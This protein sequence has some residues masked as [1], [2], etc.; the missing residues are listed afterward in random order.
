MKIK[1]TYKLVALLVVPLLHAETAQE[2]G[3]RVVM[4][5]LD[6]LGG[7]RFLSMNDR[8]ESGRAYSFYR[9]KLSGLTRATIYTRYL[10]DPKPATL[11]IRE[12]QMFGK[13][14]DFGVLITE[15]GEGWDVT[16][17]GARP[18]PKAQMERYHDTTL[19]NIF[20]ILRQ[21]LK[22]PGMIFE[23]QG[24]D[25]IDNMPVEIVDI[26]DANNEVTTVYF[27]QSSKLPV[28]QKF[29][30]RDPVTRERHE[31][32]TIFSKYRD[33]GGVQWPFAIQRQR[34]GDKLFE[35]YSDSVEVNKK[36]PDA[37]FLLPSDVKRLKPV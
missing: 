22:E 24:S 26:S 36:L 9:E 17:R 32:V 30:R 20:Y 34:D 5:A 6:A 11:A 25:V 2:R 12:R 31:E 15:D 29:L 21:R 28:R 1:L 37:E 10:P 33:A 18:L 13:H 19:H 4:A 23:S 7:E 16:F 14:E 27:H 35:M 8:V 3:K